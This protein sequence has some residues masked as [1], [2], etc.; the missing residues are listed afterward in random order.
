MKEIYE[1]SN[2]IPRLK[3]CIPY[4]R[5]AWLFGLVADLS[6]SYLYTSSVLSR[7]AKR[8]TVMYQEEVLAYAYGYADQPSSLQDV[9]YIYCC[10]V[11]QLHLEATRAAHR[12]TGHR[13]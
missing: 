9:W 10:S 7:H 4:L 12:A 5:F 1:A 2:L 11:K 13:R 8:S 6:R 3:R